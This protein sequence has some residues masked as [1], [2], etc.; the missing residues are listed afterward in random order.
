MSIHSESMKLLKQIYNA[1]NEGPAFT[2]A[3]D[4][5]YNMT[6]KERH[7][8]EQQ[9]NYLEDD[10]YIDNY[11][12]CTGWP[13]SVKITPLGIRTI[14]EIPDSSFSTNITT[15]Y[16]N[17]YGITGNNNTGNTLNNGA[18]FSDIEELIS[19]HS[20]SAEEKELLLSTLK[21]LYDRIEMG[22]PIE[23]GMLS[24]VADKLQN[25][26]PLLSAVV[27]SVTTFLTANK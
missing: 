26:Q 11:A 2:V 1:C 14:E 8:L 27:N 18:S 3:Q 21:P 17:N 15:I 4:A 5:L 25:F 22:A 24:T 23:K 16:G 10:G 13:I 7:I 20:Y 9:V 12:P 19:S 6:S